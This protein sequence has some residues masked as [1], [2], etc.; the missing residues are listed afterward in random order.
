MI[1]KWKEHCPYDGEEHPTRRQA[2]RKGWDFRNEHGP[3]AK[4][5]ERKMAERLPYSPWL[6]GYSA[7]GGHLQE[8]RPEY[9]Q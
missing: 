7:A 2:W 1:A 3:V 5:I 9:R 4:E 8:A 6:Q